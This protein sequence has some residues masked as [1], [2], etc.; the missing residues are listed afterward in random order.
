MHGLFYSCDFT[1]L[2]FSV[3]YIDES[4]SYVVILGRRGNWYRASFDRRRN[5]G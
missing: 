3:R 2:T 4:L 5:S 1:I